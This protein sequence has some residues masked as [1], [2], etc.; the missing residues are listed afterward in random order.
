MEM[1]AMLNVLL[2][3]ILV[4]G[5]LSAPG[6]GLPQVLTPAYKATFAAGKKG[7]LTV[8]FNLMKGYAINKNPPI[9]LKLTAVPGIKLDK[10]EF[11]S[12]PNDP[13]ST[14]EY[15]VDLP[16]LKVP[17]RVPSKY[18]SEARV[19]SSR[20]KSTTSLP[21][22]AWAAGM[23]ITAWSASPSGLSKFMRALVFWIGCGKSFD[24]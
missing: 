17:L 7:D 16:T 22:S 5:Q 6:S 8:S 18:G 9:S 3:M 11:T 14:D 13:K 4:V 12:S 19:L 15:Y 10:M 20:V 1:T 21:I 23:V 2:G 24:E